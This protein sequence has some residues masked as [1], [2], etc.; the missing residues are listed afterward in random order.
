MDSNALRQRRSVELSCLPRCHSEVCCFG[1]KGGSGVGA[2]RQWCWR[3]TLCATLYIHLE[4][5]L[6]D[7]ILSSAL[8]FILTLIHSWRTPC[9]KLPAAMGGGSSGSFARTVMCLPTDSSPRQQRTQTVHFTSAPILQFVFSA[10][11]WLPF[12]V[13]FPSA[14]ASVSLACS[15][16]VVNTTSGRMK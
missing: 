3:Q 9:L 15:L 12:F 7:L 4:P 14:N 11:S 5:Y 16:V 10:H 1:A 13:C 8:S 2:K 6:L